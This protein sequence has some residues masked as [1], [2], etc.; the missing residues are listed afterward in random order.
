LKAF[1]I[2][3]KLATK[4]YINTKINNVL[5]E[6]KPYAY[7]LKWNSFT[8]AKL[9]AALFG[10]KIKVRQTELPFEMEGKTFE[11]GTLVITRAGNELLGS[12]F[13]KIIVNTANKFNVSAN[14]IFTGMATKGFDLGS[15]TVSYMKQPK[16][17]I[18]GGEGTDTNAFG[19][20]WHFF[21]KQLEYP[22]TSINVDNLGNAD[23]SKFTV[24]VMPSGSYKALNDK[25]VKAI[26]DWTTAGGKLIAMENAVNVFVDKSGF[27]IKKKESK[28]DSTGTI[29]IY[30]NREREEISE[31]TPGSIY[32]VNM[33]NT[34]PLAFGY[35][36]I[37]Y[38]MVLEATDYAYLKKDWNV[39]VL[40]E[41]DLIAGFSGKRAQLKLKNSLIFGLQEH[42]KGKI[43]YLIN[44][45]LYRGFWQ[46]GKLLFCNAVFMAD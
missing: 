22:T 26:S 23:L 6:K 2:K 27:E 40:K 18:I 38:S 3:E 7:L 13:E 9:L 15:G 10:K 36:K 34:N 28:K 16:V 24:I 45:P 5:P 11:R 43:I 41:N 4:P 30:E 8:D 20:V 39:G 46:N 33:E 1:A 25:L 42:G 12:D 14:A 44:N 31:G 32:A 17:A 21:D 35:D 37:Y 19:E 29:K